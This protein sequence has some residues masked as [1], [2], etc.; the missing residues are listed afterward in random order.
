MAKIQLSGQRKLYLGFGAMEFKEEEIYTRPYNNYL[1]RGSATS[2]KPKLKPTKTYFK[3]S[4]TFDPDEQHKFSYKLYG[5]SGLCR[6][7]F[8]N[9]K[10]DCNSYYTSNPYY[11]VSGGRGY[12]S[13]SIRGSKKSKGTIF[14]YKVD[15]YQELADGKAL[16]LGNSA[17]YE[18]FFKGNDVITGKNKNDW[19]YGG[20]GNDELDSKKGND[21]LFPGE[22][23]NTVSSG[24]GKD[25]IVID[26]N[27]F[28]TV[29]DYS[30]KHDAIGIA[31][32]RDLMNVNIKTES[33][34]IYNTLTGKQI[35]ELLNTSS[36][37]KFVDHVDY[38]RFID[39]SQDPAS[40]IKE[41]SY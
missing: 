19:L 41:Y 20:E 36:M 27:G 9:G 34:E 4:I 37:P 29:K 15:E 10:K 21:I 28:T 33:V 7:S 26:K 30:R 17:T 25:I 13:L 39:A 32:S 40:I 22:G 6:V 18:D 11:G 24:K 31:M 23:D 14:N 3:S 12:F 1:K 16:A 38:M 2:S 35:A 5:G 8:Y